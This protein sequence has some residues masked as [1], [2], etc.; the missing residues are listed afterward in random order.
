MTNAYHPTQLARASAALVH[1]DNHVG[2]M[3]GV[4]VCLIAELK[5]STV[6]LDKAAKAL[7]LP[8]VTTTTSTETQF[9][10]SIPELG[11]AFP[12]MRSVREGFEAYVASMPEA[13][14]T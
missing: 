1:L 10:P 8:I 12:A 7:S 3:T 6:G 11:A 2:V 5:H 14:S 13:L 9:G 4:R